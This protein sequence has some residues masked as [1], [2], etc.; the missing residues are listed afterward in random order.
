MMQAVSSSSTV[1]VESTSNG[2]NRF[3]KI[4]ME[5]KNGESAFKPFFFNF[6]NGRTLFE[7]QYKQAVKLY[8][9]QNNGKMLT[10]EDYDDEEKRLAKLGMTPDQAIWRRQKISTSSPEA[11]RVEFPAT[12][13]ESFLATGTSVF[14]SM[15]VSKLQQA[16]VTKKHKA[17]DQKSDCG[18][19]CNPANISRQIIIIWKIPQHGMKYYIGVDVSEGL[20]GKHDYST[21][22]VMDKDGH[23]VAE[24]RNNSIKPYLFADIVDAMG[25]WYNKALLTVEKASGGHSVIERLDTKSIT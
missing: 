6:I 13:E 25:R 5:A 12:P 2:F 1:I 20:G 18:N 3:S 21:M 7:S 24:F 15:K 9:A 11:F 10:E 23:Q 22:F 4:Y 16:L 14:D 17:F 19:T 8:K